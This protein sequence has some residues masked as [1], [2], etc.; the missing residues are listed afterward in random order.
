[1]PISYR[2]ESD[3]PSE[4]SDEIWQVTRPA[5]SNLTHLSQRNQQQIPLRWETSQQNAM[6][7]NDELWQ[8]A[9]MSSS[10]SSDTSSPQDEQ[11]N[12]TVWEASSQKAK[13]YML[14]RQLEQDPILFPYD[15]LPLDFITTSLSR[16]HR[17]RRQNR[18]A[19]RA[20]RARERIRVQSLEDRLEDVTK[21]YTKLKSA[22]LQ[23]NAKYQSVVEP[24][25]IK[26]EAVDGTMPL[27]EESSASD[28]E[29]FSSLLCSPEALRGS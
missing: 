9:A 13:E 23:L 16:E 4:Y 26:E 17:R 22:Y 8:D 5:H 12:M 10:S 18:D 6:F 15:N 11:Q 14:D 29:T 21:Q 7:Y 1:M 19:Q 28:F 20:F 25:D 24:A 27:W 2:A 3:S